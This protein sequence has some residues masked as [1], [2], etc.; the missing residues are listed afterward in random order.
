[1]NLAENLEILDSTKG[2]LL[3][4]SL[5]NLLAADDTHDIG[6]DLVGSYTR[7]ADPVA[8]TRGQNYLISL[9]RRTADILSGDVLLGGMTYRA[10][11]SKIREAGGEL[12]ARASDREARDLVAA[13]IEGEPSLGWL[14]ADRYQQKIRKV[15]PGYRGGPDLEDHL[16]DIQGTLASDPEGR[17]AVSLDNLL[18]SR[19]GGRLGIVEVTDFLRGANPEDFTGQLAMD[20]TRLKR[21]A[22][23]L[24]GE[25]NLAGMTYLNLS[26][27]V[28]D[29]MGDLGN[30]AT[31]TAARDIARRIIDGVPA[32]AAEIA[33]REPHPA[34]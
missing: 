31:S 13:I 12:E 5:D 1:M 23:I 24:R 22:A 7:A 15:E 3:A 33:A 11:R 30:F 19:T 32:L 17:L 16:Q 6:L 21:A 4:V 20:V 26:A 9:F 28:Q 18:G 25:I 29:M 10:L 34:F 2:S 8:L 14:V 27:N